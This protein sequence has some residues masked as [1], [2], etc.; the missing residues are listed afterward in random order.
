M[1]TA[2]GYADIS[3]EIRMTGLSRPAYITYGV[4]PTSTSASEVATLVNLAATATNSLASMMDIQC[5]LPKIRVSMG[6]DGGEDIVY[7]AGFSTSGGTSRSS[8][9]PNAALLVHKATGRGGRRGRGRLFIPWAADEDQ[10]DESGG[11]GDT[12][13]NA[14]QTKLNNW[15]TALS[16][17]DVP[18]VLLHGPGNTS[19]GPPDVVTALVVDPLISTQRRRLGR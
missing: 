3:H 13:R 7:E 15:L 8:L 4:N 17:Q 1:P 18:M 2:P 16:A 5:T 19:P 11:V 12:L 10:V 6:T 9:P 14:L